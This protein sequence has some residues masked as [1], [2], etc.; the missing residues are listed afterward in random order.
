VGKDV[1]NIKE[2]DFVIAAFY[3]CDGTCWACRDGIS[4]ACVNRTM[5]GGHGG[6]DGGQ[7]QKVRVPMADGTLS[8]VPKDQVTDEALPRLLPLTDVLCTG[9]HAA[10]CARVDKGKTVAVIG[11][12]AVG[13]CGVA[14]SK[15]LGAKR[16]F[17]VSTHEDRAEIGK[18]FGATDIIA[19]R[20][21]E[22]IKQIKELTD[23]RG[24]DCVLESV[25]MKN[26]WDTAFGA[27]RAGGDI[28]FVGVPADPELEG[29][30]LGD[31]FGASVGVKGGGAPAAN[32]IKQLLPDVLAGK[33]DVSPI[34]TKTVSLDDLAEGYAAMDQRRAIKTMVLP[35]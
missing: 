16:I 33:L 8:V 31:L 19:A 28:G 30:K 20:G 26:S 2:G 5:W 1:K 27:V 6:Y 17:L 3:A 9:H 35:E 32:Y 24:V 12:G 4:F 22:A 25:G 14:A 23:G 13:L 18:Q 34:F 29:L 11:D 7:G 21:D 10:V 15:R